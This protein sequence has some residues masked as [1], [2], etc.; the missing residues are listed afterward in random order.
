MKSGLRLSII[1]IMVVISNS[2]NL[3]SQDS[4]AVFNPTIF[5]YSE[6]ELI[7]SIGFGGV[8]GVSSQGPSAGLIVDVDVF[9]IL[10]GFR[11]MMHGIPLL[12]DKIQINEN[13]FY[14]GYQY[15]TKKFMSSVAAGVGTM[16]FRCSSNSIGLCHNVDETRF[17][18]FPFKVEANYIFSSYFSIGVGANG[19]Y[20]K[21]KNL[22]AVMF[23]LKFGIFG[24]EDF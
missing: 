2:Q 8:T 24:D 3:F 22:V 18:S 5:K 12:S 14:L 17:Q 6:E 23:S 13:A 19:T 16:K 20:S 4:I 10:L 1:L 21:R 9:H 11:A 7:Y 15:R